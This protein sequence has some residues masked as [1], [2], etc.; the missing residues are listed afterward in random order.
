MSD[1]VRKVI[2]GV[3]KVSDGVRKVADGVRKVSD[4]VNKV[5]NG[6]RNV[7]D[8]VRMAV[9]PS[10]RSDQEISKSRLLSDH[11]S[12]ENQTKSRPKLDI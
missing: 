12:T 8:G 9:L 3:M 1:V 5:S 7:S 10:R 4:G 2:D 11:I 6:V